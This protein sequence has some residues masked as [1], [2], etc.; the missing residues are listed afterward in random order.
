M[1][2]FPDSIKFDFQQS[3]H[4]Q[5]ALLKRTSFTIH[6]LLVLDPKMFL[7]EF[8]PVVYI[9]KIFSGCTGSNYQL[10]YFKWSSLYMF[11]FL[12]VSLKTNGSLCNTK[13]FLR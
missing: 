12:D 3:D 5:G 4:T 10:Y 11:I 13:Y 2:S 6:K 8:S 9:L 7:S 1:H